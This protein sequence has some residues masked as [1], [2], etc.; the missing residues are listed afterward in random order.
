VNGVARFEIGAP[1][2][3]PSGFRAGSSVSGRT[4]DPWS[5]SSRQVNVEAMDRAPIVKSV[6]PYAY[7]GHTYDP[8]AKAYV[9]TVPASTFEDPD[10]DPL[11]PAPTSGPCQGVATDPWRVDCTVP[12]DPQSTGPLPL[13]AI[14]GQLAATVRAK[15]PFGLYV[16]ATQT[17]SVGNGA[18]V[19][20]CSAAIQRCSCKCTAWNGAGDCTRAVWAF[21][22]GQ[23]TVATVSDPDHDLLDV[24]YGTGTTARAVGSF[25]VQVLASVVGTYGG[26]IDASDGVLGASGTCSVSIGCSKAN[27]ACVP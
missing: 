3:N 1:I 16:E 7:V 27:T 14:L 18:P 21:V 19:I 24:T 23:A 25:A 12:F 9:A 6:P 2:E 22:P 4:S 20:T 10:G 8:V 17:F 13:S 5:A 26:Q 11:T 15:D